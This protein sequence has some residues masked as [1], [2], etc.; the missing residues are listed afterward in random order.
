MSYDF[1]FLDDFQDTK[2]FF[3]SEIFEGIF[4]TVHSLTCMIKEIHSA[5][6]IVC[7]KQ[8]EGSTVQHQYTTRV[9]KLNV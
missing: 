7:L 9:P 5:E 6:V 8:K 3:L 1:D 4:P 2:C